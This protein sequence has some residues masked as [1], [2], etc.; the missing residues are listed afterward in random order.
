[1]TSNVDRPASAGMMLTALG[2]VYGDL[3]T[4]PL[5]AMQAVVGAVGPIDRATALGIFSAITWAL[6]L[7]ISFKYCVLVLRADNAGEGGIL[8]LMSLVSGEKSRP[9]WI[10][11]SMGLFGAALIYGDGALTP[12]I[13]VLSAL[14]GVTVV[15]DAMKP[16]VLPVAVAVLLALFAGQA[17]GTARIGRVFGP[18]MLLWFLVIGAIGLASVVH[19][20]E[21]LLAL[22]PRHAIGLLIGHPAGALAILGAVFLV[23]TGGE[24]LY[25]DLGH[26][27]RAPIRV[28]WYAVVL[29]ALL[30]SYAGQ[31]A[32]LMD[33]APKPGA[34]PFWEI[35][36]GWAV[37][38]MVVLA[39][40]ATVIASQAIIT[41]AFSMTRQAMQLGWLPGMRIRQ[42]SDL[43][44]GQIYVPVVNWIL[45]VATLGLALTFGSAE[46][47]AGAYGTAV[48][49]TMLLTTFLL[50]VVMLRRWR[51]PTALAL[52]ATGALLVMDLAF[53]VANAEKI[54]DG[55]WIPLLLG[56]GL[57]ALMLIWWQG[58]AAIRARLG[59]TVMEPAAFLQKLVDGEIPRVPGAAVF[60]TRAAI[61]V[62]TVMAQHVEDMGALHRRIVSL[63]V[64]FE[65]TPR[66]REVDRVQVEHIADGFWHVV[67]RY[68]FVEV[69]DLP[70]A[71]ALARRHGCELAL[72]E[73]IYFGAR[74]T[75]VAAPRR[76]RLMRP[77]VRMVF[78]FL[79]RNALRNVDRFRLP[80]DRFVEVGRQLE[81]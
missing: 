62:P 4:S 32:S 12:A 41:G 77:G 71:L 19:R 6:L 17:L 58:M 27:G 38:P 10:L 11:T 26:V 57:F 70:G 29:P 18:I 9:R 25:A 63:G 61:P 30:L 14:E 51:W 35:M 75:V 15:T 49:T 47:L 8:A 55:G 28:A 37:V 23:L 64:I 80:Q 2:I 79:Y 24:A 46:R 7:T 73:A 43:E 56:A 36:P 48:S 69:P 31:A 39:T 16:F 13:S 60:L 5:Y 59:R 1:M 72:D 40:A 22:D 52:V 33:G 44:Y 67:A 45:M 34:N 74:D 65:S 3:G 76:E 78:A 21:V 54:A 68:G 50:A 66:V 20:P 42:T 81:L 53:F